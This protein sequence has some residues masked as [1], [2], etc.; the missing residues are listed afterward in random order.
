[1]IGLQ[2]NVV[3]V[4]EGWRRRIRAA[5]IVLQK[6]DD[7]VESEWDLSEIP[8]DSNAIVKSHVDRVFERYAGPQC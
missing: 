1:M 3:V 8:A 4:C 2:G 7:G 6:R 5:M